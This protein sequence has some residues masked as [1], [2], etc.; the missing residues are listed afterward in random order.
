MLPRNVE[1]ESYPLQGV[2]MDYFVICFSASARAAST[3]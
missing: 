1:G 3:V 2:T